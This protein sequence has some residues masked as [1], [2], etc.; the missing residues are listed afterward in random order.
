MQNA[1][2]VHLFD[3]DL[4]RYLAGDAVGVE[5]VD[6]FVFLMELDAEVADD[7]KRRDELK[8]VGAAP[9]THEV[10]RSSLQSLRD[11]LERAVARSISPS[12]RNSSFFS[13]VAGLGTATLPTLVT[14]P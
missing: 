13:F 12:I 5:E 10:D 1:S 3:D 7:L 4:D 14:L 9:G 6:R 2:V 8:Y 11:D